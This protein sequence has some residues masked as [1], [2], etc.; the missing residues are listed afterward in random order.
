MQSICDCQPVSRY[1][2]YTNQM[3]AWWATPAGKTWSVKGPKVTYQI[4]LF[5][6]L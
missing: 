1:T 6:D 3:A 5:D 2:G 4:G